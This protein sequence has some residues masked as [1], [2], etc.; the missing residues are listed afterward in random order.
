MK[1]NPKRSP[2]SWEDALLK[3]QNFHKWQDI[4]LRAK[5]CE[6]LIEKSGVGKNALERD[7]FISSRNSLNVTIRRGASI[8]FKQL[9]GIIVGTGHTWYDWAYVMDMVQKHNSMT[10]GPKIITSANMIQANTHAARPSPTLH[11]MAEDLAQ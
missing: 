4:P 1:R 9:E 6:L 11:P 10:H 2:Q 3:C 7:G 5:A 8:G